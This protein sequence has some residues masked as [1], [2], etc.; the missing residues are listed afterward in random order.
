MKKQTNIFS[1]SWSRK[2]IIVLTITIIILVILC[3]LLS[4]LG[5]THG[6]QYAISLAALIVA[7]IAAIG[8]LLSLKWTRDTIRPFLYTVGPIDAK[9]VG[10]YITLTFNIQNSG[11][12]PG[13]DVQTDIDFFD[14]DE[15][16]TGKNLSNKYETP[17]RETAPSM[18]FPNSSYEEKYIF[19][20]KQENDLKLWNN[21]GKGKT[22]CRVRIEYKSLGREHTTIITEKLAKL[23]SEKNIIT[24]PI[25][26]QKWK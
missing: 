15:E 25:P 24:T 7:S 12:L 2:E 16:V 11:S 3:V 1:L 10:Q 21:I 5:E 8:A 19:D 14:E 13:E 22:K 23:K 4:Y 20:L 26:P 6:F 9:R 18:L 17:T